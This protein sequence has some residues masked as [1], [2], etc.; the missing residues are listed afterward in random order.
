[1]DSFSAVFF[2]L[3]GTLLRET[4]AAQLLA[5]AY[6]DVAFA[7]F[8]ASYRVGRIS[9]AE[10]AS[11]SA[12][13]LAG[14][15]IA[16]VAGILEGGSWIKGIDDVMTA[17]SRSQIVPVLATVSWDFVAEIVAHR[18]GFEAWCGTPMR[19]RGDTL[20]GDYGAVLEADD[21]ALF[22]ARFCARRGMALED[23]AAVGDSRSDV[24]MFER[25]GYSIA[26]NADAQ[27]RAVASVSCETDDL[28]NLLPL[29]LPH[30]AEARRDGGRS[31]LPRPAAA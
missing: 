20:T 23:V 17:L 13:Y 9:N 1:M 5:R 12:L 6:D 18:Y 28:R 24:A 11:R 25:V 29:V 14:H 21:K 19:R 22:V 7:D 8:E 31:S 3:D 15:G 10:V 16:E 4:S 27:A 30:P 26:L 2:D